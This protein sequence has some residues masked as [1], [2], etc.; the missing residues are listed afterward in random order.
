MKKIIF[1]IAFA[2]FSALCAQPS[3]FSG[4]YPLATP[5]AN[6]IEQKADYEKTLTAIIGGARLAALKETPTSKSD[7]EAITKQ[8]FKQTIEEMLAYAN[9]LAIAMQNKQEESLKKVA[10][11]IKSDKTEEALQI[12]KSN[13][14]SSAENA[15][16]IFFIWKDYLLDKKDNAAWLNPT[17]LK[18]N[19]LY[20]AVLN[21][22]SK[23]FERPFGLYAEL[24]AVVSEAAQCL[25]NCLDNH[26]KLSWQGEGEIAME[27]DDDLRRLAACVSYLEWRRHDAANG[28]RS[29]KVDKTVVQHLQ[30]ALFEIILT[31]QQQKT[32][33]YK[34]VLHGT[35]LQ[36]LYADAA[37]IG[38]NVDGERAQKNDKNAKVIEEKPLIK[39]WGF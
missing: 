39:P 34:S 32:D 15:E 18:A 13:G 20:R 29:A 31:M 35:H 37:Q 19:R 26:N 27:K 12:L 2:W 30:K 14:G 28:R 38:W 5:A 22:V 25:S 17:N 33:W 36:V 9:E 3:R 24:G 4:E 1:L 6:I 21:Y 8:E 11:L 16:H 10:K 23:N 7:P